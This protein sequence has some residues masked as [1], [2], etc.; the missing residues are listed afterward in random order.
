MSELLAHPL[1]A[2]HKVLLPAGGPLSLPAALG[3]AMQGLEA[4][5]RR[6]D[7]LPVRLREAREVLDGAAA[8]SLPYAG[9]LRAAIV[10]EEFAKEAAALLLCVSSR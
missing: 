5:T 10:L 4:R 6:I 7:N 8:G 2:L 3:A 1:P 9:L